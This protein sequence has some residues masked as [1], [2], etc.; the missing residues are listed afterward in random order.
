MATSVEVIASQRRRASSGPSEI[1][2]PT[3]TAYTPASGHCC[4]ACKAGSRATADV[5]AP[6]RPGFGTSS[7]S[8]REELWSTPAEHARAAT[9]FRLCANVFY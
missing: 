3:P 2:G 8:R 5:G 7:E 6:A 4:S 9:L 1:S